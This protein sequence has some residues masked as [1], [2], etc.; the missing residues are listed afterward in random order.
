MPSRRL[1]T[2]VTGLVCNAVFLCAGVVVADS[3]RGKRF[4]GCTNGFTES[5]VPVANDCDLNHLPVPSCAGISAL[6]W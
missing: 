1:E 6:P 4:R 2:E 5:V 3:V